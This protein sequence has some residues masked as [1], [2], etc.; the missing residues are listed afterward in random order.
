MDRRP[1]SLPGTI[2]RRKRKR[3]QPSRQ[4]ISLFKL[5]VSVMVLLT[6]LAWTI[7]L[8]WFSLSMNMQEQKESTQTEESPPPPFLNLWPDDKSATDLQPMLMDCPSCLNVAKSRR[9]KTDKTAR[10]LILRPPGKF[11]DVMAEFVQTYLQE[12]EMEVVSSTAPLSAP[13]PDDGE[14]D[15]V[16]H[17]V[18]LPLLLEAFDVLLTAA[19]P[20][21]ALLTADDVLAVVQHL[22]KWHCRISN[23][24]HR[25]RSIVLTLDPTMSFPLRSEKK[26]QFLYNQT[27]IPLER[28]DFAK[29]ILEHIDAGTDFWKTLL[30]KG[31][32]L[33]SK[34]SNLPQ[35]VNTLIQESMQDEICPETLP[36]LSSRWFFMSSPLETLLDSLWDTSS[37]NEATDDEN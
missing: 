19:E 10:L 14:Y 18:T 3:T 27:D 30:A 34:D 28:D 26:M 12:S 4:Q 17:V 2:R 7:G 8:L 5:L 25:T 32:S 29:K 15:A 16:I 22:I 37:F 36:A 9:G 35:R 31:S 13:F 33:R 21:K 24:L 1:K 23:R 11:G 20:T 6:G